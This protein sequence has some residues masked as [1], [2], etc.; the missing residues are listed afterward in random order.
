MREAT[1]P[2]NFFF[3]RWARIAYVCFMFAVAALQMWKEFLRFNWVLFLCFGLYWLIYL[4]MQKGEAPKAYFSKP[5]TIVSVGLMIAAM[6]AALHSL[7]YLFT[8]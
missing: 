5:R 4:P 7:N 6:A 2:S 3:P 8:K 1:A